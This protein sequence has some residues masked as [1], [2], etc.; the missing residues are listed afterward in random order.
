MK[1]GIIT[2]ALQ[3][4]YGGLLQNYALQQV[5]INRGHEVITLDQP[6]GVSRWWFFYASYFKTLFLKFLGR[7]RELPHKITDEEKQIIRRNTNYFIDKYI[8]HTCKFKDNSEIINYI[9]DKNFDAFVVGSDQVWRPIYNINLFRSYLDFTVGLKVIRISYAASFGVDKWEYSSEQTKIAKNLLKNFDAISVREESGIAL[10]Q[11]YFGQ[12]AKHVLDPTLLLEKEDYIRIVNEEHES[13]CDGTLFTY[14]LDRTSYKEHIINEVAKEFELIPFS[15]MP[16]YSINAKTV[17]DL[18]LC[19][20]PPVTKW[21]R[22]FMDAKFVI[23]DSF[24]G[25]V[26]SIIFNKPFLVIANKTRG[27]ARF[28]SLLKQFGLED[29][30]VSNDTYKLASY[31]NKN[32]NWNIVNEKK[33]A[34]KKYSLD[35]LFFYLK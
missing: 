19:T 25:V 13:Q 12:D 1:I 28:E 31:L 8:Y 14:I 21:L 26:F 22:A 9:H 17:D 32:I 35:Y 15:V 24:H 7:K 6:Y 3:S 2:Q 5:L 23:C 4:N 20:F 18:D 29:R 33:A 34:L 16:L 27:M 10:C 30:L 11:N